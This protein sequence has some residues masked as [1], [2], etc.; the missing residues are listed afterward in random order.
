MLVCGVN[1]GLTYLQAARLNPD[2]YQVAGILSRGS[3]RS[4]AV[5]EE[6]DLPLYRDP[7]QIPDDF[8]IAS[9][10]VGSRSPEVMLGLMDRGINIL[11]EHPQREGPLREALR[12]AGDLGL[13]LH[14]NPHFSDLD[15]PAAFIETCC[16]NSQRER[17]VMLQVMAAD[18]ALWGV[19][20]LLYQSLGS[21]SSIRFQEIRIDNGFMLLQGTLAPGVLEIRLQSAL[22]RGGFIPDG[23]QE[24]L[25]D[26]RA[27]AVFPSGALS[28]LSVAGPVVWNN[29]L[30]GI[31]SPSQTLSEFP[32]R[33][34]QTA[35]D[36]S[37]ER[38]AA[39][40][41]ALDRLVS[42]IEDGV[43]SPNQS[44]DALIEIAKTWEFIQTQLQA[45]LN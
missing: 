11:A 32:C 14:V 34:T 9:V 22:R 12:K 35:A 25:L 29:N 16:R 6:F 10:A 17:P 36:F 39:N 44:P 19:L 45:E 13:A 43:K 28:M 4:L 27:A 2:R 30:S 40:L 21:L 26:L 15:A 42:E 37:R 7:L 31:D 1:Y 18:R 8:D 38:T 20:D 23:S 33:G 5:S 41:Y 24:Y 3:V